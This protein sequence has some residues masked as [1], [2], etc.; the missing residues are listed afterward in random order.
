MEKLNS[1]NS[2]H[3]LSLSEMKEIVG[4]LPLWDK[5]KVESIVDHGDGTTTTVSRRYNWFGLHG[6]D[7][8]ST[9]MDQY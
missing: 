8:T 6:T 4:G 2:E 9:S 5:E 3:A 1:F 7:D